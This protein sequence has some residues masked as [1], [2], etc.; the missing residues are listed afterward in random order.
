MRTLLYFSLKD[1]ATARL[2]QMR[3]GDLAGTS[4]RVEGPWFVQR[5]NQPV[6]GFPPTDIGH[7]TYREEAAIAGMFVGAVLGALVILRYGVSVGAGATAAAYVGAVMLAAIIGWWAGGLVGVKIGRL[8]LWRQ[9]A[10]TTPGQFLMIASCDSKSKEAL[11][12]VIKE[13]GG[14]G[15]D[16]HSD[17]MPNFRWL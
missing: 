7:T 11:K 15:V 16:E 17:L 5:D 9:N 1:T 4:A 10:Q 2:A 6:E 14:V 12:Q 8:G 13:L 3:F